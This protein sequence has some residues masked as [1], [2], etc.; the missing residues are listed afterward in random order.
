MNFQT[1]FLICSVALLIAFISAAMCMKKKIKIAI[2]FSAI[3]M[4]CMV[5]GLCHNARDVTKSMKESYDKIID[6]MEIKIYSLEEIETVV[7]P[8]VYYGE[9]EIANQRQLD[10]GTYE[11]RFVSNKESYVWIDDVE[12]PE[13]VPYLLTM[14]S[15]KTID[16]KDDEI[17]VVWKDMN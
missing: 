5:L 7:V 16:Y 13:D 17:V 8:D 10:D 3:S 6:E 2:I 15:N 12:Y 4:I 1:S 14:N 11:I 9:A